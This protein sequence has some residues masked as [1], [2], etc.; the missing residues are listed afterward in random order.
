VECKLACV[1]LFFWEKSLRN[2]E[3]RERGHILN[4]KLAM[5]HRNAQLEFS[6]TY[7]GNKVA[8]CVPRYTDGLYNGLYAKL[9]SNQIR[10]VLIPSATSDTD[11]QINIELITTEF[12]RGKEYEALSYA[13]GPQDDKTPIR[14][15]VGTR[16]FDYPVA[17][18]LAA[19]LKSLRYRDK[20]RLLWI[21][22][23]CINQQDPEERSS[24]LGKMHLYYRYATNVCIWLGK[25]SD[26]SDVAM[27]FIYRILDFSVLEKPA[28]HRAYRP[29]WV[30]LSKLLAREWFNRRWVIQETVLA[31]K[32]TVC[33]G[34]KTVSW[35]DFADA[36]AIISDTK[37]NEVSRI[38]TRRDAQLLGE[39]FARGAR[40]MIHMSSNLFRRDH[41]GNIVERLQD[42]ENLLSNLQM[43]NV[44]HAADTVYAILELAR[45]TSDLGSISVGSRLPPEELFTKVIMIIIKRSGSLDTLFRPWA[46]EC[47]LPSWVLTVDGSARHPCQW[48]RRFGYWDPG[49]LVGPP[50]KSVYNAADKMPENAK[51]YSIKHGNDVLAILSV[52]GIRADA[53]GK[54]GEVPSLGGRIPPEWLLLAGWSDPNSTVP[55]DFWRTI[56]GDRDADGQSP[57]G[58]Y[59]RVCQHVYGRARG[60]GP[61]VDARPIQDIEP[62]HQRVRS[63][64]QNRRFI[65]TGQKKFLGLGPATCQPDDFIC[66]L[67]GCSVPVVLRQAGEY[68]RLVGEC[69]IHG[70]MDGEMIKAYRASGVDADTFEIL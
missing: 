16:C 24:Q 69:Y 70:M 34:T 29:K 18:N 15:W 40:T 67:F 5:V 57:P 26:N 59:R 45:D 53:I 38:L 56:V 65:I 13:W 58:W 49:A 22:A 68:Y 11:R 14:V 19:A 66:I 21:D 31:K 12:D 8:T 33:C 25:E 9:E 51:Q 7:R 44:A 17:N 3:I 41:E 27:D 35:P 43:F 47:P 64:I 54:I 23:L 63:V 28:G 37:W 61:N 10:Y 42:M 50:G 55:G 2:L 36:V 32:A 30:A 6:V 4:L 52:S 46:P 20:D 39:V 1:K 62:F 48:D 60:G